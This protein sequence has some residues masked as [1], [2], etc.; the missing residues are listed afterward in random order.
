MKKSVKKVLAALLSVLLFASLFTTTAFAAEAKTA[1]AEEVAAARQALNDTIN[2]MYAIQKEQYI[3]AYG[4]GN[5]L[6]DVNV[7][8]A[9]A[10]VAKQDAYIEKVAEKNPALAEFFT[11]DKDGHFTGIDT[12]ALN[13]AFNDKAQGVVNYNLKTV[14]EAQNVAL[15]EFNEKLETAVNNFNANVDKAFDNFSANLNK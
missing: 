6:V 14:F 2:E 11:Y 12:A 10:V 7:K 8:I 4:T 3:G 13:K 5:M 1:T 9:Q 15:Q